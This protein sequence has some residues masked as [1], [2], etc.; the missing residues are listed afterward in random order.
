MRLLPGG[1]ASA[2]STVSTVS[3]SDPSDNRGYFSA[4]DTDGK[5]RLRAI[6]GAAQWTLIPAGYA[7]TGVCVADAQND[8]FNISLVYKNIREAISIMNPSPK[9]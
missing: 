8:Y 1:P 4:L 9:N 3:P 2:V 5:S 6:K 7:K